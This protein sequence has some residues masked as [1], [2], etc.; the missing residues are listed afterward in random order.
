M[1]S[2]LSPKSYIVIDTELTHRR[3]VGG[4]ISI[5][6]ISLSDPSAMPFYLEC[7]VHPEA[8]I[9][10]PTETD[11]GALFY[12]GFTKEEILDASKP[13]AGQVVAA[14]FKWSEQFIPIGRV[15]LTG[16]LDMTMIELEAYRGNVQLPQGIYYTRD[17]HTTAMDYAAQHT[18]EIPLRENG[19]ISINIPTIGKMVG[20]E[21]RRGEQH[22]ALQDTC[23]TG[24]MMYRM[25]T[26]GNSFYGDNYQDV[27]QSLFDR[28]KEIEAASRRYL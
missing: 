7:K 14:L 15:F 2:M 12:A 9:E 21:I 16:N 4:I 11:K 20:V 23:Y 1:D 13:T 17:Y 24:E 27:I 10:E 26:D 28:R 3:A 19:S 25:L 5:S 18:M 22:H 6:A 8:Q